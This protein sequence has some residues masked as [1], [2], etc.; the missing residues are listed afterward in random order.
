MT[1]ETWPKLLLDQVKKRGEK[2]VAFRHKEYGVWSEHTWQAYFEKV[3]LVSLGL[4]DLGLQPGEKVMVLGYNDPSLYWSFLGVIAAR[5]VA[6]TFPPDASPSETKYVIGHS[7]SRLAI[8]QD[9]GQ[10]DK[11]LE[12]KEEIPELK[13]VIYWNPKGM[14]EYQDSL[15]MPFQQ[16][17][18]RGKEFEGTHPGFFG[19]IVE[20]SR[21]EDEAV[22]LYTSGTESLPKGVLLSHKAGIQSARKSL[23]AISWQE[24]FEVFSHMPLTWFSAFHLQ[25]GIHLVNGMTVNFPEAPETALADLK[26]IGPQFVMFT[27]RQ[28][29]NLVR[30]IQLRVEEAGSLKRLCYRLFL[31][32]GYARWERKGPGS[33]WTKGKDWIAS[34]LLFKP[35]KDKL[36][37][38][39]VKSASTGGASISPES[40]RFLNALGLNLKQTYGLAEMYPITWQSDGDHQPDSVGRPVPGAEILISPEGEIWVQGDHMFQGYYKDAEATQAA[41]KDGWIRTGDAG[42]MGPDGRI[43]Y[44]GRLS[45]RVILRE[46]RSFPLTVIEDQLRFNRFIKDAVVIGRNQVIGLIQ[47]DFETVS[48]WAEKNNLAYTTFADLSQK[49]RVSE[50]IGE[51]VREVNQTLPEEVRVQ[52]YFLLNKPFSPDEW[53]LTRS[54]KLRRAFIVKK[55][56]TLW[57]GG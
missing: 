20:K 46:G 23:A 24:N 26:E 53:E 18:Q 15:L 45:D 16:L 2:G 52:K 34:L 14:M 19:Q 17:L 27:P 7:D 40:F 35:L 30:Q 44:H 47:I 50:L 36:G 9:Q 43:L 6:T 31:P 38:R 4:I 48:K 13:K 55:H 5:G 54:G 28:W 8:V 3:K 22:L 39:R 57:D 12:I 51:A 32:A 56:Q 42:A 41:L 25:V 10:V 37:L 33:L 29:E 49:S 11:I 21:E 1:G